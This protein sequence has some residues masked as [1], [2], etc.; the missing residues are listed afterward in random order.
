MV[1]QKDL[2]IEVFNRASGFNYQSV[3]FLDSFKSCI[4][5][6]NAYNYN[7][8]QLDMQIDSN[9]LPYLISDNILSIS[10]CYFY[11]DNLTFDSAQSD[12]ISLY[13]KSL[14]GKATKRI[15][16]PTYNTNSAKPEKIIYDLIN[17]NLASGAGTSRVFN[18]LSIQQ[19]ADLGTTA[20]AYQDSYDVVMD[21]VNSLAD[22]NQI[23]IREMQTNLQNPASQIQLY[24]GKD[25]SGDGGV[26]FTLQSEALKSESLTRDVSNLA[27]TAYV[28]GEDTGAARK[29]VVLSSNLTGIERN[30]L[31]VDARDLQQSV[32]ND[33]G[34]TTN[35]SDSQYQAQLTQRGQQTLATTTEV[36]QLGGGI[37]F[38]NLQFVY[39]QDYEVG[40]TVRL[41]SPRFGVSKA[42]VLTT[43]QET[44]DET[45]YHLDPTFDKDRISLLQKIK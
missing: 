21:Q 15:V 6:W 43:M 24:K 28:Y 38:N 37:D 1:L 35:L 26:E 4:V 11:I 30:E 39:G 40:D 18:Y 8:F 44:W 45:G 14:L 5:L 41:T 27:T 31:Y 13:G 7:T 16:V 12:I 17:N 20:L 42:S 3:D 23:C 33:D 29:N 19:P 34:T 2:T 36:I 32:S 9:I 25:L 10:D 22:S